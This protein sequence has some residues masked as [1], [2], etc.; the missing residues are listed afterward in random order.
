[1]NGEDVQRFEGCGVVSAEHVLIA[2]EIREIGRERVA[3]A[4][5]LDRGNESATQFQPQ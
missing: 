5:V 3:Y 4:R 1:M 2:Q